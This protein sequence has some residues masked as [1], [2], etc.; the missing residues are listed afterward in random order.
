MQAATER[1][2]ARGFDATTLADVAADAGVS[3]PSVAFHFGNKDGLLAAVMDQYFAAVLVG[4]EAAAS[5]PG[6]PRQ[7][8]QA[9]MEF[10]VRSHEGAFD[11][12]SVF[13][14]QGGWRRIE[15]ESGNAI[16]DG[17]RKVNAV[18]DRLIDD[19]KSEGTVRQEVS[20]RLVRDS[21][22]GASE[23][24]MRGRLHTTGRPDYDRIARDLL[25][26]VIDGA[27]S[28]AGAPPDQDRLGTIEK[29]IDRLL[30]ERDRKPR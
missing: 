23:W 5:S 27:A 25:D 15:S 3:G 9:F 12:F 4:V 2:A 30:K 1:F 13:A 24:V 7:R 10:W 20:T 14:T 28:P 22:L 11:L 19:M 6:S 29:K 21:L 18:V 26:I 17:Y 16:R 8:L